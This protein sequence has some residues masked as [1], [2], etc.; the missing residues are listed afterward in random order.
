MISR[1]GWPLEIDDV[2]VVA[3]PADPSA[4][5]PLQH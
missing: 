1:G 5:P 4:R 2:Q 3:T